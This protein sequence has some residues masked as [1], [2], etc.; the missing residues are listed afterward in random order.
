VLDS[1]LNAAVIFLEL[2]KS[3]DFL[4]HQILLHKYEICAVSG[5][6][7][8]WFKSHL[9]NCI[10]FVETAKSGSNNTLHFSLY[11][12]TNYRVP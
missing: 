1:H 8:S 12:E 11:I 5:V 9:S 7:K 3:Y 4:N 6:L 2:S 10:Q